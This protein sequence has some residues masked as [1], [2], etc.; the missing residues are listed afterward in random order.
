P[1]EDV[2]MPIALKL[3]V[4]DLKAYYNEGI[5]AQPGHEGISSEALKKWFWETTVAGKVLT[6]LVRLLV[7]SSDEDMAAMAGHH[8]APVDVIQRSR[9]QG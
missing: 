3:A 2:T 1:R 8:L 6:E 7:Q 9:Q 5:T 4:E